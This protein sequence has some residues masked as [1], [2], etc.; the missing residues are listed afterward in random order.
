[1]RTQLLEV[2][3]EKYQTKTSINHIVELMISMVSINTH[4]SLARARLQESYQQIKTLRECSK[5]KRFD[6]LLMSLAGFGS[7]NL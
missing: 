6:P 2:I 4:A 1:M 7:R 5:C 3:A